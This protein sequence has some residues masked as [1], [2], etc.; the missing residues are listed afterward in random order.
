MNL[1]ILP[2]EDA[3]FPA[4]VGAMWEAFENPF[5][6]FFRVVCPI[7]DNDREKSLKASVQLF[8]E[9]HHNEQPMS[10]WIKVVDTDA[11]DKIAGAARWVVYEKDPHP[12]NEPETV[13]E[14][15]PE[16]SI[17][18]D[19]ATAVLR[20]LEAPRRKLA[21]RAHVFLHVAFTVPSYRRKGVADMFLKWGTRKADEMGVEC[22]LDATD[23]GCRPYQ[24]HGFI[25]IADRDLD[26]PVPEGLSDQEMSELLAIRAALLPSHNTC[27]WRP[28]GGHYVE[29]TPKPWEVEIG[30]PR[31]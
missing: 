30:D 28:K 23:A 10:H 3:E 22:W 31:K 18:R 14:W 17:G 29:G 1:K 27:M 12:D 8:L 5:Q 7:L 13:A 11:N 26:P 15:Y 19:F 2:V 21:R 16:N 6:G 9:E 25:S 20:Q 24:R 4:V